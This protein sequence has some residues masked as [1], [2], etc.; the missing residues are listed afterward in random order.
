MF[1]K[2]CTAIVFKLS[3]KYDVFTVLLSSLHLIRME[4]IITQS[5]QPEDRDLSY[6]G[7][8]HVKFKNTQWE[9]SIK[10]MMPSYFTACFNS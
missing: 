5:H 7:T 8:Q 3:M 10:L 4:I 1:H 6:P 2:I 9:K